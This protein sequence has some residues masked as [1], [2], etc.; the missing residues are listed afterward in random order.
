MLYCPTNILLGRKYHEDALY[1]LRGV[2]CI[3]GG[4]L[5]SLD[6]CCSLLTVFVAHRDFILEVKEDFIEVC[7]CRPSS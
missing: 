1:L 4:V 7:H 2:L 5:V 6:F 3:T